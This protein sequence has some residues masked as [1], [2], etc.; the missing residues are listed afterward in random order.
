MIQLNNFY[1][2]KIITNLKNKKMSNMEVEDWK[3]TVPS[4]DLFPTV[5]LIFDKLSWEAYW[6]I[7]NKPVFDVRGVMMKLNKER[8]PNEMMKISENKQKLEIE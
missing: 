6:P 5:P 3:V 1:S 2:P 4:Y 7:V 8:K